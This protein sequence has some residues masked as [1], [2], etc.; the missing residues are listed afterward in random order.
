MADIYLIL[1]FICTLKKTVRKKLIAFL[2]TMIMNQL[3]Q[4]KTSL[5]KLVEIDFSN[6]EYCHFHVASRLQ[7]RKLF[8]ETTMSENRTRNASKPAKADFFSSN[9]QNA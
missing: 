6:E 2:R 5:L 8:A 7:N 1:V 9:R 3:S 4:C